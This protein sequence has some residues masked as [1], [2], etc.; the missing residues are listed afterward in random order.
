VGGWRTFG[1]VVRIQEP[2]NRYL[3]RIELPYFDPERQAYEVASADLGNVQVEPSSTAGAKRDGGASAADQDEQADPFATIGA[4]RLSLQPFEPPDD[5]GLA[6]RTLW[7]LVIIPPAGVA[8]AAALRR[9]GRRLARR[10][11]ARRQDAGALAE[12]ALR[13]MKRAADPQARAA[14]AER[15]LHHA[16]E[17]ATGLKS[18]GVLLDE[19]PAQLE[20]RGLEPELSSELCDALA[21][22]SN[23]RFEPAPT[24]DAAAELR[25]RVAP[26]VKRLARRGP[27]RNGSNSGARKDHRPADEPGPHGAPEHVAEGLRARRARSRMANHKSD[28]ER[29]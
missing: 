27:A 22:C 25:A 1:Y 14:A 5:Q 3:G 12:R 4:A 11:A 6:P 2:G 23:I 20:E 26:L 8:L 19:L 15:A 10:R 9:A 21:T 18:R 7:A 13:D 17:A 29:P 24:D 28:G 16:I